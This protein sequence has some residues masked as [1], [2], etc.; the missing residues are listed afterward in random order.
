MSYQV[1]ALKWRPRKFADAVGQEAITRTLKNSIMNDKVGH[2]YLLTGTRGIGKTTIARIF[3]KAIRC[4]N[5]GSDGEPC[6]ECANCLS[7][8]KGQSHGLYRNRW[9]FK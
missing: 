7:I 6:L 2:A 3:A 5:L 1:L 8:D 9:C 4:L